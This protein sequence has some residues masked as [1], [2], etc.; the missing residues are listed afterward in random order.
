[1]WLQLCIEDDID[2]MHVNYGISSLNLV[3]QLFFE[4]YTIEFCSECNGPFFCICVNF[5]FFNK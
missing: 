2:C 4:I 5:E 3:L 1:M